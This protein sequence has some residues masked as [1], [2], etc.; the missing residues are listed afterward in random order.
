MSRIVFTTV[1]SLGDLH[2]LIA[3]GRK[4]GE[5]GHSVMFATST[6][7]KARITSLGFEFQVL[8]PDIL[9]DT[10]ILTQ[11][12]KEVMDA[13]RGPERLLRGFLFPQLRATYDDLMQAMASGG[14]ADL[15]V[16]GEGVYA[17]RLIAE[18]TAVPW[19]S[20]VAAPFSFFSAYDPPVLPLC[21]GFSRFLHRLGLS[22][23]QAAIG[24]VKLCTRGWTKPIRQLRAELKLPPPGQ[25]P[26]YEGRLSSQLVLA[27]FSSAL[28]HAQPDWPSH[29]VI[30]GFPFYDGG[31]ERTPQELER[32]LAAGDAP[33]VFTLGSAVVFDPGNFYRESVRAA[34]LLG[35]RAILLVGQ[36]SPPAALPDHIAAFDY[37]PFSEIFPRAAAVVHQ[38]G[39]GTTAQALRAGR[40]MLVMPHSYDQPDNATRMVGLGVARTLSRRDYSGK[41]AARELKHLLTDASYERR[42]AEIGRQVAGEDG[43]TKA[44][45]ALEKLLNN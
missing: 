27:T 5:R 28:A 24:M 42:A 2:P 32:F 35:R 19:A 13:K 14:G 23:N 9:P 44:A 15:L 22:T 16:S 17:A 12:M 7:H 11:W 31:G 20:C 38:G 10:P 33:I 25:D 41:R 45:D 1:G 8:R 29:T 34:G 26:I 43:A 30:T 39:I 6:C 18:K 4:L 36:N 21:P 37:I 40:P 3:M